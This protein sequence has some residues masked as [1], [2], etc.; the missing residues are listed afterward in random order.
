V[1]KRNVMGQ[2][3]SPWLVIALEIAKVATQAA[4][5]VAGLLATGAGAPPIV[6]TLVTS[7]L[8]T[9][10]VQSGSVQDELLRSVKAD[11]QALVRAPFIDGVNDLEDA[12]RATDPEVRQELIE[13][14]IDKFKAAR[15]VMT[16]KEQ[17]GLF[18]KAMAEYQIG[19][20][21]TLLFNQ[22]EASVWFVRAHS[23]ATEHLLV[24][25]SPVRAEW[26]NYMKYSGEPLWRKMGELGRKKLDT[27]LK[28]GAAGAGVAGAAGTLILVTGGGIL[29]PALG[30]GLGGY[31]ATA[32][33][34][35][36]RAKWK[37]R[38]EAAPVLDFINALQQL[39]RQAA[40]GLALRFEQ[41]SLTQST[42]EQRL[43]FNP[44]A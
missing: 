31:A 42:W 40:P 35:E 4:P 8:T 20:C 10:V 14:A 5:K 24:K 26:D 9:L 43:Q 2:P 36:W 1:E 30:A 37:A 34:A 7:G 6:S 33:L 38:Q 22:D 32:K 17:E 27:P 15:A 23:S 19:C 12:K 13:D 41:P 29:V 16:A 28:A 21:W 44:P 39:Q 25:G 3:G 11:T 18:G